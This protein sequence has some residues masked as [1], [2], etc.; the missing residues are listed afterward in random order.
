M[1]SNTLVANVRQFLSAHPPFSQ[2]S[3]D[4][5]D[6]VARNLELASFARDEVLIE[7]SSGVPAFCY[8]LKQGVVE[9]FRQAP[10]ATGTGAQARSSRSAR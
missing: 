2:M 4:D 6:F 9:G 10:G 1:A 7:P 3:E 8:I 5:V